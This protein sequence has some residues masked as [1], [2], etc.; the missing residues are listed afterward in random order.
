MQNVPFPAYV[1]VSRVSTV[2]D[3]VIGSESV[4]S[5]M[6]PLAIKHK[7][8]CVGHTRQLCKTAELI[9]AP[10]R[11]WIRVAK[12]PC[13]RCMRAR[14]YS[15]NRLNDLCSMA[16]MRSVATISVVTCYLGAY[17]IRY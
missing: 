13:I 7:A 1:I 8:V 3:R 10:F 11:L 12:K 4:L 6:S 14:L 5:R 9:A 17:T 16:V 15:L 2:T